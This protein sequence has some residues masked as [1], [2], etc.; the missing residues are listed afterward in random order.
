MADEIVKCQL[1]GEP[2]PA[3]EEMFNYH[4]YSGPCPKPP[5]PATPKGS[6]IE[7]AREWMT[8][9]SVCS[10]MQTNCWLWWDGEVTYPVNLMCDASGK[11]FASLGQ[12][13]WTRAQF[14]TEM[15][16]LWSP[17]IVPDPPK[18]L[19]DHYTETK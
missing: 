16:G 7:D 4:G 19:R 15:G 18:D 14:V 11:M 17:F 12:W 8:C 10:H 13:G 2:M 6:G 9:H 5:L 1:C 3:G